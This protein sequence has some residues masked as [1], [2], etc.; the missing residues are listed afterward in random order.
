M[1]PRISLSTFALVGRAQVG[2]HRVE[3]EQLEEVPVPADRR[4]RAAVADPRPVV[5]PLLGA[6]PGVGRPRR[7]SAASRRPAA[8]CTGPSGPRSASG[9]SGPGR[10]G[11]P[12]S[13]PGTWPRCGT[14]VQASGGDTSSPSQV[15]WAGIG[16]PCTNADEVRWRA[17]GF[18][19]GGRRRHRTTRP[20]G[21]TTVGFRRER[22]RPA[23][24]RAV[25]SI[26]P[27]P[28]PEG[29]SR[30]LPCSDPPPSARF[31]PF[32]SPVAQP[33]AKPASAALTVS[34][35][36]PRA[37]LE[38]KAGSFA[39]SPVRPGRA[40]RSRPARRRALTL[41]SRAASVGPR[42]V[43][44]AGAAADGR[45]PE[46]VGPDRR[47]PGRCKGRGPPRARSRRRA[48]P[49]A[50][51]CTV[52]LAGKPLHDLAALSKDAGLG[53]AE[54]ERLHLLPAGLPVQGHPPRLAGGLPGPHRGR[55]GGA[56]RRARQVAAGP[57]RG[58]AGRGPLLARRPARR[59][60]GGPGLQ[61]RRRRPGRPEPRRPTRRVLGR[62]AARRR[63]ASSPCGS[64]AT[65]TARASSAASP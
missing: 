64:T 29:P 61:G 63:R 57:D 27:P 62:A 50:V 19:L 35:G 3:G 6:R 8:G 39:T 25:D 48:I 16:P 32:R 5:R 47:R 14:P 34:F 11:R 33:P 31:S 28:E 2:Q 54:R 21:E 44:A 10:P 18:L 40:T 17:M 43:T 9:R 65:P 60:E 4:A 38:V 45:G 22:L 46:C 58:A 20:T 1:W 12:R 37:A 24:R 23:P 52:T 49:G 26:F 13:G 51:S 30:S 36:D 41:E 7:R 42:Q 56:S 55:H 15:Y 53:A 59:L